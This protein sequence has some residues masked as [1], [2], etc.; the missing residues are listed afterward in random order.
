VEDVVKIINAATGW[1][2]CLTDL[3]KIG[4]RATNLARIFNLREGLKPKDDRLP[5]R[6]FM[7]SEAGALAGLGI[8]HA[9]F[10]RAMRDLYVLKD[11]NLETGMPSRQRLTD[12]DIA[13]ASDLIEQRKCICI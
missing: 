10:E 7:P 12:L 13:W 4:E 2:M 6:I 9:E 1:D 3:L 8:D 11:W 5:E